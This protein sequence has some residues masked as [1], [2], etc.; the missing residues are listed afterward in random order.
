MNIHVTT[1]DKMSPEIP[2]G[3]PIYTARY[4]TLCDR[5]ADVIAAHD[6]AEVNPLA[7]A[8]SLLQCQ[9]PHDALLVMFAGEYEDACLGIMGPPSCRPLRTWLAANRWRRACHA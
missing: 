6:P 2:A 8:L 3:L 1:R 9:N 5:S 7:K 4:K